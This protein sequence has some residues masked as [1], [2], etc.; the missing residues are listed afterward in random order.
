MRKITIIASL[1]LI[2]FFGVSM[3][4][5]SFQAKGSTLLLLNGTN[6]LKKDILPMVQDENIIKGDWQSDDS[7]IELKITNLLANGVLKVNCLNTKRIAIERSIWTNSSDVLRISIFFA[8]DGQPGYSLALNYLPLKD[9][10]VGVYVDGGNI[11]SQTVVY[12]RVK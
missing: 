7:S 3:M 9:E 6:H 2:F 12:K 4:P 5:Y 1:L 11:S 10:L 8:Q